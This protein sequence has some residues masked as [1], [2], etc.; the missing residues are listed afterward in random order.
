MTENRYK[1]IMKKK[2]LIIIFLTNIA[3]NVFAQN[4]EKSSKIENWYLIEYMDSTLINK[5]LYKFSRSCASYAY[6]VSIDRNK[7]DSIH[8]IGY[9][10][11]WKD[12]L[13]KIGKSTYK[14]G[15]D[16]QYWKIKLMDDRLTVQEFFRDYD[17][18]ANVFS[19]RK[20]IPSL[21]EY[22][23]KG[24]LAGR[25]IRESDNTIIEIN[26][27]FTITGMDSISS[28]ELIIDFWDYGNGMDEVYLYSKDG[29]FEQY[30]W[31]FKNNKLNLRKIIPAH[32]TE[33][34]WV[35]AKLVG[36][37]IVLKKID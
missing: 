16:S 6:K 23:S 10:E 18:T 17:T 1:I 29:K 27:D 22:F 36:E 14:M 15:D 3:L 30:H 4:V 9:H 13:D 26:K 37:T 25:Y 34:D 19:K 24:I 28:Y 7:M 35:D 11:S 5:Q 33:F 31:W 2:I 20:D 8:F 32:E 12:K 21:K